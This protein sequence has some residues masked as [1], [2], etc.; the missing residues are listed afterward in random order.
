MGFISNI[1][2]TSAGIKTW[3]AYGIGK[4]CFKDKESLRKLGQ[5][6]SA[7]CLKIINDFHYRSDR[8]SNDEKE[9]ENEPTGMIS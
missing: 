5:T 7:T 9:G 1:E 3:R 4:G 2:L 8:I 6:K